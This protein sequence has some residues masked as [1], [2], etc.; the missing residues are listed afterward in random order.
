M[1]ADNKYQMDLQLAHG[2]DKM[3]DAKS[4]EIWLSELGQ[5]LFNFHPKYE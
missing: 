1:R 3:K 5:E 2:P 4:L